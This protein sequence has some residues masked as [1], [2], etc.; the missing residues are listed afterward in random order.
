MQREKFIFSIPIV[1]APA[2]FYFITHYFLFLSNYCYI[3]V[4]IEPLMTGES[5]EK[6]LMDNFHNILDTG[7]NLVSF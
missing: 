4:I 7:I 1:R 6:Y 3:I 5:V 2:K